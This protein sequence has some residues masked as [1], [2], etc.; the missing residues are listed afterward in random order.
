MSDLLCSE[1]SGSSLCDQIGSNYG[2]L[3]IFDKQ[4]GPMLEQSGSLRTHTT[5]SA[6]FSRD[7]QDPEKEYSGITKTDYNSLIVAFKTT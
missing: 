7:Y 5:K 1:H 2:K 6:F 4:T 3:P